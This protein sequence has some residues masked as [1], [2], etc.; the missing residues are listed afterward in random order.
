MNPMAK[1]GDS[2][3]PGAAVPAHTAACRERD[4]TCVLCGQDRKACGGTLS[5]FLGPIEDGLHAGG[6]YVHR[7]CALWSSEVNRV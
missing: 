5:S 1:Q 3:L 4:M 7:L 2:P 6:V